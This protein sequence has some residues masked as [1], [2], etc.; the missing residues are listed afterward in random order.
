M[1]QVFRPLVGH[2]I[3]AKQLATI[4]ISLTVHLFLVIHGQ[5]A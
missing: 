5:G 3:I 2:A 4:I 1:N